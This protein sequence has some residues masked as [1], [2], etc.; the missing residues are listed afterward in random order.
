MSLMLLVCAGRVVF[1]RSG[2]ELPP[3]LVALF[4]FLPGTQLLRVLVGDADGFT[5]LLDHVLVGSG[6]RPADGLLAG[7]LGVRPV[8]VHVAARE[9]RAGARVLFELLLELML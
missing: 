6:H 8:G 2:I 9:D 1:R 5:E 7:S 4:L 3:V